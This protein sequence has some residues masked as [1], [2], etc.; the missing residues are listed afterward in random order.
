[1]PL[2]AIRK[3]RCVSLNRF[4]AKRSRWSSSGDFLGYWLGE[5][6]CRRPKR[7]PSR[8]ISPTPLVA[9]KIAEAQAAKI[10]VDYESKLAPTREIADQKARNRARWSSIEGWLRQDRAAA[11]KWIEANTRTEDD[12]RFFEGMKKWVVPEAGEAVP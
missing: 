8:A 4:P 1:V 7:G 9:E 11:L 5:G 6:L 10:P 2:S 12:R 3:R